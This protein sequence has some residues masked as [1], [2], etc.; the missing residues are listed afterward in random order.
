LTYGTVSADV[1]ADGLKSTLNSYNDWANIVYNGGG[2]I[3]SGLAPEALLAQIRANL[4][5]LKIEE[6]T[7]EQ[8]LTLRQQLNVQSLP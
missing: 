1:N 7:Y 4:V 5:E 2:A 3:G 8:M 6:L